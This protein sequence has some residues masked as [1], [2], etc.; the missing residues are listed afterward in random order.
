MFNLYSE[1]ALAEIVDVEDVRMGGKNI[2]NIRF[3]NDTVL[4]AVIE[5]KLQ[6]VLEAVRELGERRGFKLN[7]RKTQ[8]TGSIEAA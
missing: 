7:T 1:R 4:I 5:E 6:A 8:A 3:T 2:N